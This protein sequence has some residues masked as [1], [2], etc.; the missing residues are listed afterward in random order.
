MRR[1]GVVSVGRSDYSIL[2]PVLN[3]I[4]K[5]PQLSLELIVSGMHLVPEFGYTVRDIE[6]DGWNIVDRLEHVVAADT[7]S[8]I[9]KSIGLGVIGFSDIFA[10]NKPDILLLMGDRFEMFCAAVAAQPFS[11]P[12]AHIHGGETTEGAID[13]AFRHSITKMSHIHFATTINHKNRIIQLGEDPKN[14]VISGAPALDNVKQIK[15]QKW[16]KLKL[17]LNLCFPQD[18]VPFLVTMHPETVL[19]QQNLQNLEKLFSAL[20]IENSTAVFTA[21]NADTMGRAI[22]EAIEK[23]CAKNKNFVFRPN[24]GLD[25]YYQ[26]MANCRAVIGNSS[27]GIIEAASFKTPVINVGSRQ[28]GRTKGIN[29]I[30][31][32]FEVQS[33]VKSIHMLKSRSFAGG[34]RACANPYFFGGASKIIADK[35]LNVELE[36]QLML[37]KFFDYELKG[38]T[39]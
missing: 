25:L 18:V 3:S 13:E 33:I 5:S 17:D 14:V 37:K 34:L 19:P 38:L 7:P 32:N 28:K 10:K 12:V 11:L 8:G 16:E 39:G 23:R 26:F 2:R 9:S 27:S 30:D 4:S 22:N 35:L 36:S 1:V 21:A 29:V 15:I 31:A 24:L 6:K 20:E